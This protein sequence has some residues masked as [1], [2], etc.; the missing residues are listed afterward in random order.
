LEEASTIK[1]VVEKA[2]SFG[3]SESGTEIFDLASGAVSFGDKF[4]DAYAAAHPNPL[5]SA[6]EASV[7]DSVYSRIRTTVKEQFHVSSEIYLTRPSFFSRISGDG[8]AKTKNDEYWHEHVDTAQYGTF[9][10][11][12][13]VY[14]S[15][16]AKEFS[17]GEFTFLDPNGTV[18]TVVEPRVGRL[19]L[20]TSDRENLHRVEK[21]QSGTRMAF[22]VAFTCNPAHKV[23]GITDK[24]RTRSRVASKL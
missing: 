1:G 8:V 22:T 13:L 5:L 6:D 7:L 21:V 2:L 17:G 4:L 12:G 11:T 19:S 3:G 24:G 23:E 15:T 18:K 10:I 9:D 20:F 14:L 16:A